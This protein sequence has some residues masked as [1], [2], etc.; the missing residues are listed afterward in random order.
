MDLNTYFRLPPY[1]RLSRQELAAQ[2][3]EAG[4]EISD[5]GVGLWIKNK[6]IP[7]RWIA[8]IEQILNRDLANRG[9]SERITC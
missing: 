2:L 8:P 3:T 4:H 5:A 7:D 9:L 1:Q 6:S